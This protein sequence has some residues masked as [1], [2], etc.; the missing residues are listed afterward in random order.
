VLFALGIRFVGET[1]AKYLAQHFQTLDAIASADV[2][3][4]AEAEEVG[5]KIAEAI[6]AYFAD[7]RNC[8]IVENLRQAGLKFELERKKLRSRALEGKSVVISGKFEGRSRDDMKRLV[9]EHG[10]KNLAAVSANVDFIVAGDNM[11]PA[12]RQKAEKLGVRI[13]NEEEFM[14]L[15]SS[16]EEDITSDAKV[17]E[18]NEEPIN[19][20]ITEVV[21]TPKPVPMEQAVQGVLF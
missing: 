20:A 18:K 3:S 6:V 19:P 11:G 2:E 10:G 12:K 17:E 13:L 21:D 14:A 15:I 1:T 5:S 4:L 8:T 7:I 16:T 9:E